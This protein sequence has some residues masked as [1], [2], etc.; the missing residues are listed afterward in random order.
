MTYQAAIDL[1]ARRAK[2][3]YLPVLSQWSFTDPSDDAV[4]LL[5]KMFDKTSAQV[6]TDYR[7]TVEMALEAI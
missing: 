6:R 4:I 7:V 3:T 2:A 5:A 1:L